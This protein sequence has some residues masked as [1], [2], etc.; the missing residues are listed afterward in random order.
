MA[1]YSPLP[2]SP[3]S[4]V[5]LSS[6]S[7]QN[8][9]TPISPHSD[10][11]RHSEPSISSGCILH[12]RIVAYRAANGLRDTEPINL[13]LL[14]PDRKLDEHKGRYGRTRVDEPRL[15]TESMNDKNAYV[16][17]ILCGGEFHRVYHSR[18][19]HD[20]FNSR[21]S[22]SVLELFAKRREEALEAGPL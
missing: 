15:D 7:K 8:S 16:Y 12:D 11:H 14:F 13:A 10:P 5:T 19:W 9:P 6:S 17:T 21:A 4:S 18:T 1:Y 2:L 22:S 3:S 20:T